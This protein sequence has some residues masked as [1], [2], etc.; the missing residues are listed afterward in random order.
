MALDTNPFKSGLEPLAAKYP[1]LNALKKN[2]LTKSVLEKLI[3][4]SGT[5]RTFANARNQPPAEGL[6]ARVSDQTARN[7]SDTNNI[8]QLLPD[9]ELAMQILVSSILSPKDMMTIE[10]GFRVDHQVMDGEVA[11]ILI[12]IIRQYFEETYKMKTLLPKI[13]EE[14]LFTKGSYPILV[15]PESSLDEIING[16]R[17]VSVESLKPELGPDQR[18]KKSI[19]LLGSPNKATDFWS[20]EALGGN[21]ELVS[22]KESRIT[23]GQLPGVITVSDNLN[24]LKFPKVIAKFRKERIADTLGRAGLGLEMQVKIPQGFKGAVSSPNVTNLGTKQVEIGGKPSAA[25]SK[26]LVA[27]KPQKLSD[28][29]LEAALYKTKNY[30]TKPYLALKPLSTL[31]RKTIGHP[32]II[33]LP[34]ECIIPVHVPGNPE[35][36]VGYF[37]LL[38]QFGNPLNRVRE[39]D[40]YRDLSSNISSTNVSSQLLDSGRRAATGFN[41]QAVQHTE[42][43]TVRLYADVVEQDLLMRLKNGIYGESVELSRPLDVYRVMLARA[44]AN[45]G[46]QILY[47]PAELVTYIAFDYNSFGV[48]KSLLEDNKILASIR[49]MLLFS[50][51]MSAIKNSTGKT[52]VKI[53]LDPDDPDPASTVEYLVHEYARNRQAAYPLGASNPLDIIDFLQ[54]AGIDVQVSGNTAYPETR[55]LVEDHSSSKVEVDSKLEE[56]IK[57]KYFMSLGLSPETI[58]MTSNIEFATS[59]VTSNLLLAK[60]VMLYQETLLAFIKDFIQK[61]VV[62]SSVLWN[63]LCSTLAKNKSG[64]TK[65]NRDLEPEALVDLFLDSLEITLPKPDSAQ[66]TNQLEAYTLYNDALEKAIDAYFGADSFML[67]D[68][69]DVEES[70]NAVRAA[71]IA[72]YQREWLRNNN[73]LPE[74][75]DL[76]LQS[77]DGKP[78]FN[79]AEIHGTHMQQIGLSIAEL[80]EKL[81]KDRE[82]RDAILGVPE[83]TEDTSGGGDEFGGDE[84]GE[85]GTGEGEN[86]FGAGED[87][88]LDLGEEPEAE[89]E[90]EE[91][92]PAEP[93]EEEEE[94]EEVEDK[95]AK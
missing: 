2:P 57:R 12:E 26:S 89:A 53:E 25:A 95:K 39:A 30:P 47:V 4:E 7:I 92:E 82:K 78:V 93:E 40:Y 91:E 35:D 44:L 69:D 72:Y 6:A 71:V 73:V 74:L 56:D 48:G 60:R 77:D 61:Y 5:R 62:N 20:L 24:T 19:G 34:P 90:E 79:L 41:Q 22:D 70:F 15:L 83:E 23:V 75:M 45:Q 64:L 86:D 11:G 46:T 50:S 85:E 37:V 18:P 55:L 80:I 8:F 68:F 21:R 29:D 63:Q 65:E 51:T 59:I 43:E 14:C 17:R 87:E 58:D 3:N 94:E 54:N 38:D 52:S 1:K 49:A 27:T 9:T 66:L 67:K 32:I 28:Q 84:E 88:D 36:H 16:T 13:L 10:L 31:E 42:A 76:V 81:R 33:K